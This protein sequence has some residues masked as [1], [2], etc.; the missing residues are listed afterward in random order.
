MQS[1]LAIIIWTPIQSLLGSS[2]RPEDGKLLLVL[3]GCGLRVGV[4]VVSHVVGRQAW[5]EAW[6]TWVLIK[7]RKAC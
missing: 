6:R 7:P 1:L 2:L 4:H 5:P 3:H